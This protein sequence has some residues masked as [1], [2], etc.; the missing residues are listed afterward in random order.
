MNPVDTGKPEI[1]KHAGGQGGARDEPQRAFNGFPRTH[2]LQQFSLSQGLAHVQS[3]RVPDNA[4]HQHQQ[5]PV[6]A[7]LQLSQQDEVRGQKRNVQKAEHDLHDGGRIRERLSDLPQK[8]HEHDQ[9]RE[10]QNRGDPPR[11]PCEHGPGD[12]EGEEQALGFFR[13]MPGAEH[14][15]VVFPKADD[16]H[17]RND[18]GQDDRRSHDNDQEQHGRQRQ[19]GHPSLQIGVMGRHLSLL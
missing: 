2:R 11:I 8:N 12:Q 16:D 17:Q 4:D 14:N 10:G 3:H 15:A 9:H 7:A 19:T 13:A 6:N 1:A 5:N 18:G